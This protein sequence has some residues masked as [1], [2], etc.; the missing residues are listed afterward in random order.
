MKQIFLFVVMAVCCVFSETV[1]AFTLIQNG[2]V[3]EYYVTGWTD[4][5]ATLVGC[6]DTTV[7]SIT[8]PSYAGTHPVIYVGSSI[9]YSFENCPNLVSVTLPPEIKAMDGAFNRCKSLKEFTIPRDTKSISGCFSGCDSLSSFLVD[10]NNEYFTTNDGVLLDVDRKTLVKYPGGKKDCTYSILDGVELI[11]DG[12]FAQNKYVEEVYIPN[13]VVEIGSAA[14]IYCYALN[15]IDIPNSV[16]KIGSGAFTG[17]SSL[18]N[19]IIPSSVTEMSSLGCGYNIESLIINADIE[20]Y[21]ETFWDFPELENITIN[22]P[23]IESVDLRINNTPKLKLLKLSDSISRLDLSLGKSPMLEILNLPASLTE[24]RYSLGGLELKEINISSDNPVYSTVDGVLYS[25]DL[26]KLLFYPTNNSKIFVVPDQVESIGNSAFRS[27]N[28]IKEI[29]CN[30]QECQADSAVILNSKI[31]EIGNYAFAFCKNLEVVDLPDMITHIGGNAFEG[32]SNLENIKL[33][34]CLED[35]GYYCFS[36]SKNNVL[37]LPPLINEIKS[38]GCDTIYVSSRQPLPNN[39]GLIN[40]SDNL[41][42]YVPIGYKGIYSSTEGWNLAK[43][44]KEVEYIWADSIIPDENMYFV[45]VNTPLQLSGTIEPSDASFNHILWKS[46][47]EPENYELDMYSGVFVGHEQGIYKVTASPIDGGDVEAEITVCVGYK[48]PTEII[49]PKDSVEVP[50]GWSF[51]LEMRFLP[52]NA[53]ITNLELYSSNPDVVEVPESGVMI[54]GKQIGTA[55]VTAAIKEYGIQAEC[56]VTVIPEYVQ[57]ISLSASEWNAE[58]GETLHLSATVLPEDATYKD[59]IWSSSDPSVASVSEDGTVTAL[60]PGEAII[61]ATATDGSDVKATCNV[62]VSAKIVLVESLTLDPSEWIGE[63]V[64]TFLIVASVLPENATDKMLEWSSSDES[65][66]TVDGEGL[67]TVIKEGNCVINA[68]TIDGSDISAEC[69]I[70]STSGIED[71][72]L[73]DTMFEV[74]NMQGV[75]IRSNCRKD[76]LKTLSSGAYILDNGKTAKTIIIR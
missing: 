2:L 49:F 41:V 57:S 4:S 72:F 6:T 46:Q 18:K 8:V 42:L 15:K 63:A 14:F 43:E 71:I 74:F 16:K 23:N 30:Q 55:T 59:I 29:R 68:R 39:G 65:V 13:S 33:P 3:Y 11:K 24:F 1:A 47:S 75:L 45:D 12:A 62:R 31:R 25:K 64:D 20:Y 37:K 9:E 60:K 66:A 54:Y 69:N 56:T 53:Y 44:I 22:S 21:M 67:V 28:R 73:D 17:T 26:K 70:I 48:K 5:P 51:Y 58:E 40:N 76:E 36:Y 27:N 61:S 50:I 19:L 10:E 38:Y 32:T 34:M 52:E 35:L 7:D